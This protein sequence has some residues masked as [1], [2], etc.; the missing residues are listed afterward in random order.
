M[1]EMVGAP[2]YFLDAQESRIVLPPQFQPT[3]ISI[4]LQYIYLQYGHQHPPES[5]LIAYLLGLFL[6]FQ[7]FLLILTFLCQGLIICFNLQATIPGILCGP[8]TAELVTTSHGRWFPVFVLAAGVN[9]TGAVIY[10][11]Q[12]SASQVL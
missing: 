11:S 8:L 10:Y 5:Y 3:V 7:I 6:S 4:G 2:K 1:S 9:F 12:S